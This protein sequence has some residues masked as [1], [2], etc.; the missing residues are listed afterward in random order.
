MGNGT[1]DLEQAADIT[2]PRPVILDLSKTLPTAVDYLEVDSITDQVTLPSKCNIKFRSD[3]DDGN[4]KLWTELIG[5]F[6]GGSRIAVKMED[7]VIF[8]GELE[9]R[10][11]MSQAMTVGLT[12]EDDKSL[13]AR[14]PVHG[15][16]MWDTEIKDDAQELK[17]STS[18][19]VHFNPGGFFNCVLVKTSMGTIPVFLPQAYKNGALNPTPTDIATTNVFTPCPW[20][21]E[22]VIKYLWFRYYHWPTFFMQDE[23]FDPWNLERIDQ[24]KILWPEIGVQSFP[25]EMKKKLPDISVATTGEL[26]PRSLAGVLSK[27]CRIGGIDWRLNYTAGD[28]GTSEIVYYSKKSHSVSFTPGP[29]N[30]GGGL[31]LTNVTG[32]DIVIQTEGVPSDANIAYD[33]HDQTDFSKMITSSW[34]EGEEFIIETGLFYDGTAA[35]TIE[36]AWSEDE[37]TA[38]A[39]VISGNGTWARVDGILQDGTGT[40]LKVTANTIEAV[41]LARNKFPLVWRALRVNKNLAAYRELFKGYGD[42][43]ESFDK[44]FI[45]GYRPIEEDQVQGVYVESKETD[46]RYEPKILVSEGPSDDNF[47]QVSHADGLKVTGQ[48]LIF[49]DGLIENINQAA[50]CIYQGNLLIPGGVQLRRIKL[51]AAFKHDHRMFVQDEIESV[52]IDKSWMLLG[53]GPSYY[54]QNEAWQQ[55]HQVESLPTQATNWQGPAE[56]KVDGNDGVSSPDGPINRIYKNDIADLTDAHTQ[57]ISNMA[58]PT[59]TAAWKY[60]SVQPFRAGDW[61]ENIKLVGGETAIIPL[62]SAISKVTINWG[63]TP[64]T[65]VMMEGF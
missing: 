47:H 14:I 2:C 58:K 9:Q 51:N 32:H 17:Y 54:E 59:R 37:E 57:S 29:V 5:M 13:L 44:H 36:K 10:A 7:Q 12:F 56:T 34:F 11:R 20:T 41:Q 3:A 24:N 63:A 21:P 4:N 39:A 23:T 28:T 40:A 48:G 26:Y 46:T 38:F 62:K 60:I 64:N 42:A 30:L 35:S 33:F 61:V 18:K 31:P 19:N 45:R 52:E 53:S 27:I 43:L 50:D 16:L 49:L 65:E 25:D 15:V 55:H 8:V 1:V 22:R 6:I